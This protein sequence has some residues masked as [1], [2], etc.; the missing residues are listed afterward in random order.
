MPK[1]TGT[2]HYYPIVLNLKGERIVVIGG[3]VVAER[4]ISS[5]LKAG[6][7]IFVF[8]PSITSL[9]K[10]LA[11]SGS[12]KWIKRCVKKN[13]LDGA[14]LAIAATNNSVVNR[15]VSRWAKKNKTL[16]NVVDEPILSNFIS[17]AFFRKEKATISVHTDGKDPVFSR[18]LKNFLKENWDEFLSYRKRL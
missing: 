8:S 5:L 11:D 18:D 3:G 6:E 17:P 12:I 10:R 4:K 2:I 7:R 9:L 1:K 13:D 16:V 15:N 14:W